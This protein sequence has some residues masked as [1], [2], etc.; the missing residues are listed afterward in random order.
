MTRPAQSPAGSRWV[1]PEAAPWFLATGGDCLAPTLRVQ[2]EKKK[3]LGMDRGLIGLGETED[4]V[5]H[6]CC[7]VERGDGS[8]ENC[9]MDRVPFDACTPAPSSFACIADLALSNDTSRPSTSFHPMLR[10]I[11]SWSILSGSLG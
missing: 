5:H 10:V 7:D 4:N 3:V 8:D 11:L 1:C 2:E 9:L 6:G